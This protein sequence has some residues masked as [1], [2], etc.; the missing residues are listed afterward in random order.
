MLSLVI[1]VFNEEKLID[2]LVNR[3]LTALDSFI[4]EY[5]ILFVDDGSTDDSLEKLL[6][7]QKKERRIKI[8]SLSKNFGHQAAFTAGL[9]HAKGEV[10]AMMDGDLQDPPE[11]LSEMYSMIITEG[12]DI[13]SGKKSGRKGRKDRNLY[14]YSVPFFIQAYRRNKEHGELRKLFHDEARSRRCSSGYERK[15]QISS[16]FTDFYRIQTGIHRICKRQTGL[17]AIPR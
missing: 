5:E 16:R 8:L 10:V 14:S 13:V 9:E 15:G 12:Y 1:P 17:K 7:W 2:E 3:T 4:T 11:L 6:S